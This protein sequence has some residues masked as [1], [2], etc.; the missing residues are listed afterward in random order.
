M[1]FLFGCLRVQMNF[2]VKD[3][4]NNKN[5]SKALWNEYEFLFWL[6][7]LLTQQIPSSP[8]FV[9]HTVSFFEPRVASLSGWSDCMSKCFYY[10]SK[11][12]LTY[13]SCIWKPLSVQHDSWI[14]RNFHN[15]LGA[16]YSHSP[17]YLYSWIS[18]APSLMLMSVV[19][20]T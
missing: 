9:L 12:V 15:F 1:T 7:T 3:S 17:S 6:D 10:I 20:L 2:N 5:Y 18:C 16:I 14:F 19:S 11:L 8:V 4:S 13:L